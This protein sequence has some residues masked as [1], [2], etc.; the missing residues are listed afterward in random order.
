MD[1]SAIKQPRK[2]IVCQKTSMSGLLQL[3]HLR[4]HTRSVYIVLCIGSPFFFFFALVSR[5]VKSH[6]TSSYSF[7]PIIGKHLRVAHLA[8]KLSLCAS[9]P[10]LVQIQP[11]EE[12]KLGRL[13]IVPNSLRSAPCSRLRCLATLPRGFSLR[14][15]QDC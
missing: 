4:R 5:T 14:L 10:F 6:I 13:L 2:K 1:A 3:L 12:A 9:F 8:T 11:A 15:L 7:L